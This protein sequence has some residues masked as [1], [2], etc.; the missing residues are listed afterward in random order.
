MS[1][2]GARL[3][4]ST[5][6]RPDI[7]YAVGMLCRA[8]SCPTSQLLDDARLVLMYLYHHRGVGLRYAAV[9]RDEMRG[10]TPTPIE[11]RGTRLRATLSCTDRRTSRGPR[12]NSPPLPFLHA[13]GGWPVN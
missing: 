6:T 3:Y 10:Y 5:Q 9:D 8:M 7:A 13:R 11:L 12:K 4:C 1:L 2:L